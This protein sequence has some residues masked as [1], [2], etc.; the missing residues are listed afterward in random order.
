MGDDDADFDVTRLMS[1][2]RTLRT[3]VK[4]SAW[5]YLALTMV[6]NIKVMA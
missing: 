2:L 6:M 1:V 5:T 3:P 4:S